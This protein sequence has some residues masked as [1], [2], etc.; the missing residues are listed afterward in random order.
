[1]T[2]VGS[3]RYS[4]SLNDPV[5]VSDPTGNVAGVDD[6]TI[7]VGVGLAVT[8]DAI[9]DF[10]NDGSINGNGP[11]SQPISDLIGSAMSIVSGPEGEQDNLQEQTSTPLENSAYSQ[12]AT[13]QE[14]TEENAPYLTYHRRETKEGMESRLREFTGLGLLTGGE[15]RVVAGGGT[16]VNAYLG[17]LPEGH[18]GFEFRTLVIP[19]VVGPKFGGGIVMRWDEGAPGVID[20]GDRVGI[21]IY[22]TGARWN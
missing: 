10:F 19:R 15:N 5:N 1:M 12:P 8:A 4:Y 18:T 11:I 2:G 20:L 14:L 9:V 22:V 17:P 6:F 7:A 21:P 16:G 13:D 3:N